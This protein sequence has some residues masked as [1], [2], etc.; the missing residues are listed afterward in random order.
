MAITE[1][2]F[3]PADTRPA[4]GGEAVFQTIANDI[5]EDTLRTCKKHLV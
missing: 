1:S 2:H 3:P 4:A 5:R